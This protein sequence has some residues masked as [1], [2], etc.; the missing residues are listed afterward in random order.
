[1]HPGGKRNILKGSFKDA[2]KE[3]HS[4]HKGLDITKTP[5]VL[6]EIGELK[7]CGDTA[8]EPKPAI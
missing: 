4:A 8:I 1:M 7:K 5:L 2:S 3:F 6:L